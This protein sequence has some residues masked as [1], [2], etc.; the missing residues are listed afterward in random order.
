MPK[1]T[2]DFQTL[3]A[4]IEKELAPLGARVTESAEIA[5]AEDCS[6]REV[7]VLIEAEINGHPINIAIECRDHK[8]PQDV[9]WIDQLIGKYR[10][11]TIPFVVAVS[12]SGFTDSAIKKAERVGIR[13]LTLEEAQETDWS[14][15]KFI[16]PYIKFLSSRRDLKSAT[17]EYKTNCQPQF[18]KEVL[19]HCQIVDNNGNVAGSVDQVIL[20]L[21][22]SDAE[23]DAYIFVKEYIEAHFTVLFQD[24]KIHRS[25]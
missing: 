7:D 11:L 12:K 10:D 18:G 15:E 14:Q 1:R 21:Y 6:K 16:K 8:T 3:I 23:T 22:R 9:T 2:N 4:F 20:N 19:R 13:T 5:E 17:I 24:K 25:K